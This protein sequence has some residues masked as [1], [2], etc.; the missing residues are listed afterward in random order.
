MG[1]LGVVSKARVLC[2][3]AVAAGCIAV[4]HHLSWPHTA[5]DNMTRGHTSKHNQ[6]HCHALGPHT[7]T[8]TG[9]SPT[10]HLRPSCCPPC[11]PCC[12]VLMEHFEELLPI[13][14]VP[15]VREA[16]QRYGL[17]FKSLPRGLFVTLEDR[18]RVFRCVEEGVGVRG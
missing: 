3:P 1:I 13:V 9:T 11:R 8:P 14:S 6:Q 5:S 18:G 17:M 7:P 4:L 10:S 2:V 16:C 12:S 15:T